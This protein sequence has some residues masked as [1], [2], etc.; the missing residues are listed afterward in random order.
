MLKVRPGGGKGRRGRDLESKERVEEDA[1]ESLPRNVQVVPL[2]LAPGL[3][4]SASSC[5]RRLSRR[6]VLR[7]L[8]WRRGVRWR[9]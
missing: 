9:I 1:A 8:F 7:R 3:G 6:P 2:E 4:V 5:N